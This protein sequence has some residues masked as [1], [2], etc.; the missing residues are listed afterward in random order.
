MAA[1][2]S[3]GFLSSPALAGDA[4]V[5]LTLSVGVGRGRV[6][7]TCDCL[8][9]MA[10]G[11]A[12]PIGLGLELALQSVALEVAGRLLTVFDPD[13]DAKGYAPSFLIALRGTPGWAIFQAGAGLAYVTARDDS[14]DGSAPQS[15]NLFHAAIGARL[16]SRVR[17]ILPF[18]LMLSDAYLHGMFY[19][20]TVE[21]ALPK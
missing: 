20:A 6:E 17:L 15:A 21:V 7:E 11:P 1:A 12:V 10:D 3:A 4:G 19:G 5:R 18:E 8:G 13:R 14:N 16:A 2:L 9:D